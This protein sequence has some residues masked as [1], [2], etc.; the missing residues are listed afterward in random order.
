[1][2][3]P[4]AASLNKPWDQLPIPLKGEETPDA[5]YHSVGYA[6]STWE[7]LE[8]N[9]REIFS[10]V[11]EAKSNYAHAAFGAVPSSSG[12]IEML[13]EVL[14]Y[15]LSTEKR[16]GR[17]GATAE[18]TA[19][20]LDMLG[21]A[22]TFAKEV[23]RFTSRRNEIAHG[24]VSSVQVNGVDRGY[25]LRPARYNIRKNENH[26]ETFAKM[27]ADLPVVLTDWRIMSVE[28]YAYTSADVLYYNSQ[29]QRLI[30]QSISLIIYFTFGDRVMSEGFR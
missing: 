13:L 16:I 30:R 19:E 5:L 8:E 26:I 2:D 3:H 18:K 20:R 14:K 10:Q 12:R 28:Q 15:A 1:M 29:F 17:H 24:V 7:T 21:Q 6:L 9:L 22:I 25:L 11:I 27:T 23:S 4:N